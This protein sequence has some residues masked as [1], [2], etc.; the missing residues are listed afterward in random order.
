M[1]ETKKEKHVRLFLALAFAGVALAAM[2]FQY[3]KPVSGTGSP[4][5]LVIREG[6]AEDNP[7]V[8]LYDE[9]KQDHVLALYEVEK[10]NDFKFRLIK[11]ALLENAP[12]KLAADRDG[13]GF[14]AV[15]D[16]DWVYLDRDLEVRDRKPGLRGTITSDGE[17]FEVRKTSNHTVLETEGQYEVAFNEAGRPESVH[18]LTADHS[19]WLIMLDGGLRIASGRT[20]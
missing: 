18:A 11:S 13:A 9:K 20:M 17:P 16:G 14:W 2:Y 10:D 4:L 8:V 1:R 6:N 3:L 5:A 7:L 19:S 12:G 15:L